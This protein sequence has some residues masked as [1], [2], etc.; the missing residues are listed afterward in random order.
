M[1]SLRRRE[2]K[3][4]LVHKYNGTRVYIYEDEEEDEG[5]PS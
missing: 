1:I 4:K 2:F 5:E 3:K